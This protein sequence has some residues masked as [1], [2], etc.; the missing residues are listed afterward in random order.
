MTARA[1]RFTYVGLEIAG[2]TAI[3]RYALDERRFEETV[4]FEGTGTLESP[5]VVAALELWFLI[6]GLSYYKAGAAH[7]IHLGPT[8]VG[9]AGRRL[10]D[11]ALL[12][13]L[14][15]YAFRN[16]LD[17]SDVEITGGRDVAPQ[18]VSTDATSLL[19]PFGGG[20]DSVV[21]VHELSDELDQSLFIVSP[22]SGTFAPLESTAALTGRRVVRVARQIDPAILAGDPAFL[23][24]H[25]PVTAM[26][27]LLAVAAALAGSRGGVA[28]S[29]EHSASVPNMVV[30]GR[31]VNHQWSKSWVAEQLVAAAVA[32]RVGDEFVVA[33]VLR[34]RSE[35]W[36]AER[37]SHLETY[38]RT[39]RSCNRAFAQASERR[40]T[41]WCGECDKC[42]FIHLVLAPFMDRSA[43][44]A[45]LGVEPLADPARLEQLRTL[46]GLSA[47]RKPF[48]CVG[49]PTECAVAL[50]TLA[51]RPEWRD[52]SNVSALA[53]LLERDET[54][55][56]LLEPQGASRVPAAWLR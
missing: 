3:A 17:L 21:T 2:D 37:F 9:Q 50:R 51:T 42:L 15:E 31:D 54:L 18:S 7:E 5:G 32:E 33:S 47:Q 44:A 38:H 12:D 43:L 11:A 46:V 6:A 23:N 40:A 53:A 35:L 10:L 41:T 56:E 34:S 27:T 36:V 26:I 1:R 20:I 4:R 30:R 39:F 13:G 49:D 45:V 25:V 55:D 8:G 28:M 16:S 19:T 22:T 48:E 14:G 29:N 52:V 24:G